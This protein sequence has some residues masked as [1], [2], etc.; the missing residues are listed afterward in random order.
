MSISPIEHNARAPG[1]ITTEPAA[2]AQPE[3]LVVGGGKG[4]VGKTC[5]AVN[6][7]VE[8][9]RRGWRVV[10]VDADLGC[11]N[12][13]TVLGMRAPMRLDEFFHQRNGEG[14]SELLCDTP[15]SNL[16]LVPGTSGLLDATHPR[17][18]QKSAFHQELRLLDADVVVVDLD[19]GAHLDTLDLFLLAA[20]SGII[21][22]TPERTS[23]DNAFKFL[24]GALYRRIERYYE[25]PELGVLLKRSESL[26][27]FIERLY[28]ARLFDSATCDRICDELV[29]LARSFRPRIVVNKANTAYEAQVAAGI[30]SKHCERHLLIRPISL[31]MMFFDAT[32]SEAVNSGVPFVVGQPRR[33]V[34]G[35]IVDIANR[36][37]YF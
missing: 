5:F 13:E 19:A 27:A 32:V 20:T 15:Y 31:G 16:R 28:R 12:V 23:I 36:L 6:T 9:A 21:I 26:P 10:L 2:L 8:V 11:S 37:G 25:S 1:S 34:S 4:G 22:I 24:R 30:M 33:K 35:C 3:I 29:A 17:F 14:L 7:A 18:R